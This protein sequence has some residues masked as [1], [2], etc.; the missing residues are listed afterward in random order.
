M[1]GIEIVAVEVLPIMMLGKKG[2]SGFRQ[3][4]Q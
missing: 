2:T 3:T 1:E 4:R